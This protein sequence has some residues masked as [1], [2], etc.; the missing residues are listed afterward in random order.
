MESSNL[1]YAGFWMRA[2]AMLIDQIVLMAIVFGLMFLTGGGL[3]VDQLAGTASMSTV[4][5]LIMYLLPVILVIG[6]WTKFQATPGKMILGL[7]IVDIKTGGP[8]GVGT[9]V[10]RYVGYIV[11]SIPLLLGYFWVG[12][13]KKKQGF[14]DKMSNT[15]VVSTR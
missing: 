14:H 2:V 11:S 12:W 3:S 1:R 15:A 5:M 4:S 10:V 13:D 7:K 9:S 8:I 6:F